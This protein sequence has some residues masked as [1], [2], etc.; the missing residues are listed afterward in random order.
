MQAEFK[1]GNT[2]YWGTLEGFIKEIN[3]KNEERILYVVFKDL[4]GFYFTND[5][6]INANT[7]IALSH[8]P[9]KIKMK[10]VEPII[11]KDTLVWFRDSEIFSWKVGYYSD[12]KDGKHYVFDG[13]KKSIESIGRSHYP[14]VTTENPLN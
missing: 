5:G 11:E 7:P 1:K 10:K 9:Y 2:V 12:F 14:I 6:R 4:S 8:F 13:S 3:P